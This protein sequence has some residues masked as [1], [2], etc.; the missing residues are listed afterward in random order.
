MAH[1][2]ADVNPV[3]AVVCK[4]RFWRFPSL[5]SPLRAAILQAPVGVGVL[6][7]VQHRF[8]RRAP[9]SVLFPFLFFLFSYMRPN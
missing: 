1:V 3:G 9:F 2:I 4:T 7:T 5:T 6:L 8:K